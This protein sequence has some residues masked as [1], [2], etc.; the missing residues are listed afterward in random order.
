MLAEL[1]RRLP[2]II[3]DNTPSAMTVNG[4]EFARAV[5]EVV[6]A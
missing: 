4:R 1:I 5:K 3:R 2:Q 6:P